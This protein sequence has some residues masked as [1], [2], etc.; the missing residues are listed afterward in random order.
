MKKINIV[1]GGGGKHIRKV[2][3]N[4][5]QNIFPQDCSYLCIYYLYAE[6]AKIAG[7]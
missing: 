7:E 2:R 5:F 1:K 3:G 4:D 6:S